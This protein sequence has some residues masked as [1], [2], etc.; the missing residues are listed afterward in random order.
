MSNFILFCL[1]L[2]IICITFAI[3]LVITDLCKAFKEKAF[4]LYHNNGKLQLTRLFS[5]AR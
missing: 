2:I 5:Y 3:A 4:P 1:H